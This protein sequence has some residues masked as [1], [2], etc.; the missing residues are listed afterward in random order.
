MNPQT[1]PGMTRRL[2]SLGLLCALILLAGCLP[3][4]APALPSPQPLPSARALP[5]ATSTGVSL[6]SATPSSVPTRNRTYE[7][8]TAFQHRELRAPYQTSLGRKRYTL[9]AEELSEVDGTCRAEHLSGNCRVGDGVN[10]PG[11]AAMN[12]RGSLGVAAAAIL[13]AV[14]IV[15]AWGRQASQPPVKEI[16]PT[17]TNRP[18]LCLTCHDGIEEISPSHPVATFGCTTCHGGDGMALDANLAHAGMYGGSNPADLS[19]VNAA[20]G[21]ANCH[22]GDPATGTDHIQ[23]VTRSVQATYAGAI[24]QVRHAFGAQADLIAQMGINA[25]QSDQPHSPGAV[26]ALAAFA[27]SPND[28]QPIQKFAVNCLTCHLS[29]QPIAK[30]YFYRST[31]CAACHVLYDN[32]GL[33]KGGDPTISRTEPGHPSLHRLTTA[34]PY[35]QC[36][37]CH[38]RGNYNLPRMT[39][40]ERTDLPAPATA[41]A[42]AQRL[43]EYYQPIGQY[44]RCEWELDC[45]DCHTAQEAMGDGNIYS[46]QADAQ[47]TQCRTCHGTL[48]EPPTTMTITDPNDVALRQAQVNGNYSLQ[49]GDRVVVTERGEKL[50]NVRWEG[51]QLVLTMKATGQIYPVPLVEGSSCEQKPDEQASHY[52]H[53]C[54]AYD[55]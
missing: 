17:L 2:A 10:A 28:L 48:T 47:V 35:T 44:T 26:D 9:S 22:S 34:I 23:R 29:A 5:T 4:P 31:G 46:N 13:L 52:C 54:H 49:V 25:V 40:V 15:A 38:N 32:G 7:C 24:S 6:P 41:D 1:E 30:P 33:Y 50:G 45:V 3:Q 43:A 27:V 20:C 11:P 8:A 39:F 14:V 55:H 19:V 18:E 51:D 37:H 12:A 42:T 21:G 16:I 36:D 53:E